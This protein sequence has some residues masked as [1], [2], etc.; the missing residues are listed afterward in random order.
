M[1][2]EFFH[3]MWDCDRHCEKKILKWKFYSNVYLKEMEIQV[4][5]GVP[6]IKE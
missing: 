3:R 2:E 6:I 5:M 1:I 4:T